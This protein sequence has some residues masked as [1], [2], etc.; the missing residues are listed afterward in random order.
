MV[1]HAET[2]GTGGLPPH[3]IN[4]ASMS[5]LHNHHFLPVLLTC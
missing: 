1:D 2:V 3:L 5:C 4:C